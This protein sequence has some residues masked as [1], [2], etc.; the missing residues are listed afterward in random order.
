M[1]V[2]WNGRLQTDDNHPGRHSFVGIVGPVT[3]AFSV[4]GSI[5]QF[6]L[7]TGLEKPTKS[8]GEGISQ[9]A[10][11]SKIN[12]ASKRNIFQCKIII[13]QAALWFCFVGPPVIHLEECSVENTKINLAWSPPE[14]GNVDSYI[15][16][17]DSLDREGDIHQERNFTKVYQGPRTKYT[18]RGL[19]YNVTVLAR[20]KALNTAG[21]SEPSDEVSLSTEKGI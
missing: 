8:T 7:Q 15:V 12:K 1:N 2:Y 3:P 9:K 4:L 19:D 18:V 10:P 16:E 17:I 6:S 14:N 11:F 20:V 21:E 13:S 5:V